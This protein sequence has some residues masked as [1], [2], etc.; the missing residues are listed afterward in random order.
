MAKSPSIAAS[1][2]LPVKAAQ[3]V[4]F[5]DPQSI[6]GQTQIGV[7]FVTYD[8]WHMVTVVFASGE[9]LLFYADGV[10]APAF[11]YF[12]FPS[13]GTPVESIVYVPG[14]S[15]SIGRIRQRQSY[16]PYFGDIDDVSVFD[17]A[18][19]D[20]EVQTLFT[21]AEPLGPED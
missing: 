20:E 5:G 1:S 15:G 7:D 21:R 13:N 8:E 11:T 19:S 9:E 12:G 2:S 17:V 4:P 14:G 16:Y 10:E 3:V 6:S 18:L